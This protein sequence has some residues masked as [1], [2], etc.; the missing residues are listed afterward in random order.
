MMTAREALV[1]A[2]DSGEGDQIDAALARIRCLANPSPASEAVLEIMASWET[3]GPI[4][5]DDAIE[6]IRAELSQEQPK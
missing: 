6:A 5:L 3:D 1:N 2:W 4:P